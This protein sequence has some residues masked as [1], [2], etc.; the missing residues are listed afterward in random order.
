M[1]ISGKKIERN[2][3]WFSLYEAKMITTLKIEVY[4][5]PF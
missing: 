5:Y 2:D 4:I 1:E 3:W